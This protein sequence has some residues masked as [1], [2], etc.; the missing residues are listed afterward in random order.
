MTPDQ[1]KKHQDDWYRENAPFGR[2][3]GYPECCIKAFCDQPPAL[4][5]GRTPT[6]T[7]KDRYKAACVNGEFTGFIPCAA[8]AKEILNAKRTLASLIENRNPAFL[9]FP[10]FKSKI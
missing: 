2:E 9:P 4:L 1:M 7:E 10:Y 5:K 6:Q 3:L 8:H